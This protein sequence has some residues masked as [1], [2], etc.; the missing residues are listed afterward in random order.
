MIACGR[1]VA[2]CVTVACL[3][4]PAGAHGQSSST[5]GTPDARAHQLFVRGLTHLGLE[6]YDEAR[7]AFERALEIA[8]EQAAVSSALA[9]A[10]EG[11]HDLLTAQL[12]AAEARRLNPENAAYHRH[13]AE[14][15]VRKQEADEAIAAYEELLDRFP[16][17]ESALRSLAQ[18]YA[19]THQPSRAI[20]IY[21][22]L[23]DTAGNRTA[24]YRQKIGLYEQLG[25]T[26]DVI[27]TLETLVRLAPDDP[28]PRRELAERV[29]R[30][31]DV[32]RAIE[33]LE[34]VYALAPE[35][36]DAVIFLSELYAE[37]GRDEDREEVLNALYE[38][39]EDASAEGLVK[40]ASAL[41]D[42][43]HE[44]ED[45]RD[46]A[47]DFLERALAD[48][49]EAYEALMMMGQL[50][51]EAEEYSKAAELLSEA[52]DINPREPELWFQSAYAFLEAGEPGRAA[53][54]AEEGLVL[55]PGEFILIRLAAYSH[56]EA[57]S[58]EDAIER[59]AD[60]VARLDRRPSAP[61]DQLSSLHA[62]LGLLHDRNDTWELAEEHFEKA[63]AA[64]RSNAVALNNFAFS[65]AEREKQL[66]RALDLAEE[67][68][69]LEPDQASFLDTLG[70][71]HFK[72]GDL[73]EAE[74]WIRAAI[75]TG[76]ASAAVYEH[77]GD[78][79]ERKGDPEK[80]RE[81]WQQAQEKDPD[82]ESTS[83]R[84]QQ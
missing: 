22:R 67:A 26:K 58:D 40:R 72:R 15:H 81:Y 39:P 77:M 34:D 60:A 41:F 37:E 49:P 2:T 8:P 1:I 5:S 54:Q 24:Y 16:D 52:L 10:Y 27:A 83:E 6:E 79:Y 7:D 25:Q 9:E 66:D 65:L 18:L 44:Q 76:E 48:E 68:V 36:V 47:T 11:L 29:Y 71:I 14:L 21:Q 56:L 33:L 12:Y 42:A 38:P 30:T 82:R 20:Q 55:F 3:L 57:G 13:V 78:V 63:I 45:A 61:G 43:R 51:L 23:I 53:E 31:G 59:F 50:K 32:S 70:W 35:D 4:F 74:R 17:D 28:Q 19:S 62:M 73:S 46:A 64:D 84:L 69:R 75:E 80:A